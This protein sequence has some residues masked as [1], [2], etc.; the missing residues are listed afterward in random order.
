MVAILHSSGQSRRASG[1]PA[2]CR[3]PPHCTLECNLEAGVGTRSSSRLAF[4]T[5]PLV[6]LV[7]PPSGRFGVRDETMALHFVH[8]LFLQICFGPSSL[9]TEAGRSGPT[10]TNGLRPNT[11]RTTP[12]FLRP[13][14]V[15][16]SGHGPLNRRQRCITD[17][18]HAVT[19][20]TGDGAAGT[21]ARVQ[22][23]RGLGAPLPLLGQ[24]S[25][26]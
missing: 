18:T 1:N 17:S 19:A 23:E 25:A 22:R 21:A 9:G 24:A 26:L 7:C 2:C 13:P 6:T 20:G 11:R 12:R 14:A 16:R 4:A 3:R 8:S 15:P 5:P 10:R